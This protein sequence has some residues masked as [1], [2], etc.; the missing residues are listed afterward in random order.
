MTEF[1][2][3]IKN[4]RIQKELTQKQMA[5]LIGTTERHYQHYEAGTREPNLTTFKRIAET[6]N[7]SADYLLGINK[8]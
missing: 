2:T 7:V 5:E 6:I 4:I 3:R 8:K 1:K